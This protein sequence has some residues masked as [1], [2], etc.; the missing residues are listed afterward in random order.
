MKPFVLAFAVVIASASATAQPLTP[1]RTVVGTSVLSRQ[2]PNVRITVPSAAAYV[3]AVRFVLFGVAD[4][5]LHL[6][7]EADAS[8]KVRRLYWVQFEAYLP[9]HPSLAYTHH[10]AFTPTT[11]N[12]VP[13]Q[14]RARFGLSSEK[15]EP[16]SDAD[17]AFALLRERGYT[18][19]AETV[20]VTYKHFL[21]AT[22]RKELLLIVLDDMATTGTRFADLVKGNDLQPAWAPLATRLLERAPAAFTVTMNA[23]AP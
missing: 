7:V 17:R 3:E 4:C 1:Q 12:G 16:G 21:D 20:N 14:Q 5:E 2:D 11:L 8:K 15:P 22:M 13:F 19:P 23:G 6:F 9:E 10:P 18:L